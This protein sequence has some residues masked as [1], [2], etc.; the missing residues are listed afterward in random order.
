MPSLMEG[1]G[2]PP[3]EGMALGTPAITSN[4]AALVEV[5]GNA[6][7]HVDARSPEQLA[8]AM[9]RLVRDRALRD[10]LGRKGREH[11]RAFTWRRCAEATREVYREVM[12]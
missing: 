10:E 9:L 3:L 5:T 12:G 8:E 4:A 11:A 7:L 1:F 2:L 6:A